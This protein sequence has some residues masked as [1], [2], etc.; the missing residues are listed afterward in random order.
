MAKSRS[1]KTAGVAIAPRRYPDLHQHLERLEREGLLVRVKEPVCKDTEMHPL[2][3]WQFRG[4]IK[5]RDRKAFLFEKPVDAKGRRYD[6]P[7]AIGVL[8]ANRRIYGIGLGADPARVNELWAQARANPIPPVEIPSRAAPVHEIVLQGSELKAPGQGVD[9][10][11]VPISTPGWDN[12]PYVSAAHYITKDPESGIHNIGTYRA[13]IKAPD[14]VGCNPSLELGQGIYIHWE[15][16]RARGEK[17]PAALSIGGVPAIS[18]VAAQ[19]LN[20]D[21]DEY[22]VAGGLVKAPIRVVRAK[23]VPLLVPADAEIVIEGWVNTEFLEP[24]APFGESHG[25]VNPKEYNPYMEVTAIT[26]RRKAILCSIISQVTPSESSV[27]KKMAYEPLYLDHLRNVLGVKSVVRVM[28]HEP[29]TATQKL[30]V[31][32]MRKPSRAEVQRALMGAVAFR[33]SMSKIVIAVDDDIDPENLDA[34]F[35]A[36]GYR[37]QPH[38]D[39]QIVRGMDVGHAPRHDARGSADD[40]CLLWDATL[41]QTFPP[42]SLPKREYMERALELWNRLGLP[43]IEPES[44]WYG[45]SLGDWNDE[46]EE[47]ARLAVAGEFWKT[48][49][50][51]AGQRRP[52]K[53][54]PVNASYYGEPKDE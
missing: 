22:T 28:L 19:K 32:Q 39:V 26:R 33:P 18:Y 7:V 6:I 45:Y 34:V 52:A 24:E 40:S 10:I 49:E 42:I 36:L 16:Y 53:E 21:V 3:R 27:M 9:G 8:A 5:E 41:K 48:G 17:M 1:V 46:L 20:Y 4:G 35:W 23:T 47:E 2:V 30:T 12:A 51:I 31:V 13:M 38:R 54:T 14:R 37:S 50:K 25:H 44:P 11:P 15:K 29:L 43:R